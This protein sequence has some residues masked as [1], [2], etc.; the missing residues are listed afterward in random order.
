MQPSPEPSQA[1]PFLTA[2]V[3]AGAGLVWGKLLYRGREKAEDS[4]TIA[5][6]KVQE[7]T[8]DE[9]QSR[10]MREERAAVLTD[11]RDRIRDLKDELR[12]V[13][14][15]RET[16]RAGSELL[17]LQNERLQA[18]HKCDQHELTELRE[19]LG[20]EGDAGVVT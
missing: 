6:R 20:R 11:L 13:E 1:L 5:Q 17:A 14:A 16:E 19:R 7:A 9:I 18:Q 2:V 15:R 3:I 4:L 10:T 12:D 8:A